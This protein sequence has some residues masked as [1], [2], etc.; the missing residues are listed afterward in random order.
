MTHRDDIV[1]LLVKTSGRVQARLDTAD[2]LTG[3]GIDG[4]DATAFLFTFATR[5]KTDLTQFRYYFHY[6]GDEPPGYPRVVAL[7]PQGKPYPHIPITLDMLVRAVEQ[8]KWEYDYPA[9][10]LRTSALPGWAKPVIR[11]VLLGVILFS[12]GRLVLS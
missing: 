12:I 11:L 3:N 9:F 6:A 10:T 2:V 1:E 5:F 8:G 4:D 7:D